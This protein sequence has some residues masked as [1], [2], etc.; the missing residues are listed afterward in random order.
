M[1]QNII[2]KFYITIFVLYTF[3]SHT[4]IYGFSSPTVSQKYIKN[5]IIS[6]SPNLYATKETTITD[7]ITTNN[8]NQTTTNTIWTKE[9]IINYSNQQGI[10]ISLT[11]LGP[12][13]RAIARSKHNTSIIVGYIEGI[14]RPPN[15]IL[16]LDKMIVFKK[17]LKLIRKDNIEYKGGGTILGVGLLLGYL[18]L[19]HGYNNN[20]INAE[21]LAINDNDEQHERLIKYYKNSG[22]NVIKYVDDNIQSIPDRLIWGGCGTLL[23]NDILYMLTYW[24]KLLNISIDK[25]NKREQIKKENN[26]ET[27]SS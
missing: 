12:S 9:Q 6:L 14:I 22:F 21:F 5:K 8:I 25:Q 23:R 24:T 4:T 18:C 3:V 13:Y 17:I 20:C 27:T 10:I 11:T 19:L 16:H 26:E 2:W 7:M 15:N 1:Y